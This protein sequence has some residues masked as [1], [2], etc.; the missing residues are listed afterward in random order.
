ME[1]LYSKYA[2]SFHILVIYSIDAHPSGSPSPYSGEEWTIEYSVDEEGNPVTQ[3][4]TYQER[5][6]L[7]RKT[8]ITEGITA[9]V[10]VDEMDN[11]VW[12][13][14]GRMPNGAYLIGTDGTVKTRQAWFN[15]SVMESAILAYLN[16]H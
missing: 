16:S 4:L 2:D 12:C 9:P 15:P 7:A 8:A 6:D 11:P 10:L 13:T 14:Y 3:P 1:N 5:V